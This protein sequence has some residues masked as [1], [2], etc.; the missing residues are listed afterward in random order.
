MQQDEQQQVGDK[1]KRSA[2]GDETQP[3][4]TDDA[5]GEKELEPPPKKVSTEL[6]GFHRYYYPYTYE[7]SELLYLRMTPF[8]H[9][10]SSTSLSF[11][12][13]SEYNPNWY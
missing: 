2:E 7:P 5:E 9:Q 8:T 4:S 3:G 11:A 1:R 10:M 6:T 13:Q 12:S